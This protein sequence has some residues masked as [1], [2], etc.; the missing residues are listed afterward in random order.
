MEKSK[1]PYANPLVFTKEPLL[2][3]YISEENYALLKE[4]S[5]VGVSVLGSG[6]IIGFTENMAFRGFWF[7][8]NKMI[9]NAIFYGSMIDA[10]SSR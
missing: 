9:M 10:A 7:G 8:T 3:G 1:N 6:R 5:A 4:S 2:S